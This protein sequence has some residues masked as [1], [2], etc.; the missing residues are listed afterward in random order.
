MIVMTSD[1]TARRLRVTCLSWLLCMGIGVS[2]TAYAVD[3]NEV[4]VAAS[5]FVQ[6]GVV[7][8]PVL[9]GSRMT[10]SQSSQRAILNWQSFNIGK[11]AG[12]TFVQPSSQAV[13][14]NKIYQADPSRI[15]GSLQANGHVYLINPN[16]IVFGENATVNVGS[17]VASTMGIKDR[18]VNDVGLLNAIKEGEAA[19]QA[20]Q[21]Y[22]DEDEAQA[23]FLQTYMELVNAELP[24]GMG[25][26]KIEP[27]AQLTADPNGFVL[28][29]AP[30]IE[31]K[32]KIETPNGQTILAAGNDKVYLAE[33]ADFRDAGL[34]GMLVEVDS[35][36]VLASE[37]ADFKA[38]HGLDIGEATNAAAGSI[39]A[40]RGNI[41]LMGMAVNQAGRVQA[42][43]AVD[44]G[45]SIRLVA[46]DTRVRRNESTGDINYQAEAYGSVTLGEDSVSEVIPDLGDTATGTDSNQQMPSRVEVV[47]R[48]VR[49]K[50]GSRLTARSGDIDVLAI[51]ATPA[52]L[53]APGVYD[54]ERF[55]NDPTLPGRAGVTGDGVSEL[56]V[57]ENV[58]FDV[59]GI[60]PDDWAAWVARHPE[61]AD[62]AN[63]LRVSV[64][65]NV[66]D[67]KVLGYELRD[68]PLQTDLEN[69]PQALLN[70]A[71]LH[72]DVRD[73]PDIADVSAAVA[74]FGRTVAERSTTGGTVALKSTGSLSIDSSVEIDVSGG[75]VEYL[76]G[77]VNTT[78]LISSDGLL[79]DIADAPKDIVYTQLL[80]PDDYGNRA[81]NY[82]A[83]YIEGKDA[84]TVELF[85]FDAPDSAFGGSVRG[86]VVQ[87]RHQRKP[88]S[89]V[90][91]LLRAYN[92]MPAGGALTLA[93]TG[94]LYLAGGPSRGSVRFYA[95][96]AMTGSP[97]RIEGFG[98]L[99]VI[100]MRD[101]VL[102]EGERLDLPAGGDY[103]FSAGNI[104]LYGSIVA[105]AS[106][107]SFTAAGTGLVTSS[108]I[109]VGENAVLDASGVWINDVGNTDIV[110]DA[111]YT[112]AGA[113]SL[114]V[115][116]LAP[117]N[118]LGTLRVNAGGRV[119]ASGD[120]HAGDGGDIVLRV[121]YDVAPGTP[122]LFIG[123]NLQAYTF[124]GAADS[125][126]TLQAPGFVL[127]GNGLRFDSLDD[128]NRLL[129][130]SGV[131]T[132]NGFSA[133]TLI[134]THQGM[135][136]VDG[137]KIVV[138]RDV[139]SLSNPE[140]V[141]HGADPFELARIGAPIDPA[142]SA[143]QL[144]LHQRTSA[145]ASVSSPLRIGVDALLQVSEHP[146]SRISLQSDTSLLL[147]SGS[148]LRA[149]SGE[150][151]L[152]IVAQ[153]N[154][155]H[156][157]GQA[158]WIG[159]GA[160]IDV[161]AAAD[162]YRIGDQVAGEI[163]DAGSI[164][165]RAERGY[166]IAAPGSRFDLSGGSALIDL[167]GG[168]AVDPRIRPGRLEHAAGG[169]LSLRTQQGMFFF[170]D[171]LAGVPDGNPLSGGKVSVRYSPDRLESVTRLG[172]ALFPLI[173]PQLVLSRLDAAAGDAGAKNW[174]QLSF[175]SPFDAVPA[176]Y[177]GQAWVDPE[178]LAASGVDSLEFIVRPYEGNASIRDESGTFVVPQDLGVSLEFHGD[179][180][181][182]VPDS[183]VLDAAVIASDG[184]TVNLEAAY[185]ALG[186]NNRE[187]FLGS[188][189]APYDAAAGSGSLRANAILIDLMG[190][191]A[192]QG[193]GG[194]GVGESA[195]VHLRAAED[196]RLRGVRRPRQVDAVGTLAAA[197]SL[198]LDAGR[199]T[200]VTSLTE[201]D[202]ALKT[203]RLAFSGGR[204]LPTD[205]IFSA[206]GTLSA[207]A[208]EIHQ[209]GVLM[210]PFGTIKLDA[211]NDLVL[212]ADS[213]TSVSGDGITMPFGVIGEEGVWLRAFGSDDGIGDPRILRALDAPPDK[214]IELL[215]NAVDIQ[216]DA[217]L[218]INGGGDLLAVTFV[219]GPGGSNDVLASTNA[220]GAFA[221]IPQSA[222]SYGTWDTAL[223]QDFPYTP[224][225]VIEIPEGTGG[226]LAPGVYA[227]YPPQYA[228][229]EGAVLVTPVGRGQLRP[230]QSIAGAD[231][232]TNVAGRLG[233]AG[234]GDF[235]PNW[236]SF[237]VETFEQVSKR[238]EYAVN[239]MD[240]LF[241]SLAAETATPV[242]EL[243]K[244]AGRL[245]LDAGS[246]LNLDGGLVTFNGLGRA[247]SVD[248]T[249][250]RIAILDVAEERAGYVVLTADGLQ[251]LGAESVL[252]GGTRNIDA[253]LSLIDVTASE[254]IVEDN[255]GDGMLLQL[256]ELLLVAKD[257]AANAFE[258][259]IGDGV[260]IATVAGALTGTARQQIVL[261]DD[262]AS[263]DVSIVGLSERGLYGFGGFE[264][265]GGAQSGLKI[266]NGA[267]LA[268]N[269][270]MALLAG[271]SLVRDGSVEVVEGATLFLAA[272][273]LSFN[274]L[275]DVAGSAL[276]LRADVI[277]V[278]NDAELAF[279]SLSIDAAGLVGKAGGGS[280][281]V[282]IAEELRFENS[283]DRVLENESGSMDA[284]RFNVERAAGDPADGVA[285]H[286]SLGSG[287]FSLRN[288]AD[289]S[290]RSGTLAADGT[291]SGDSVNASLVGDANLDIAADD[292]GVTG[293][294][295]LRL[296]AAQGLRLSRYGLDSENT[297]SSASIGLQGSIALAGA[298][299]ELNTALRA[300]SG[301]VNVRARSGDVV[302]GTIGD[303]SAASQAS[304]DVSGQPVLFDNIV[305]GT[306]GGFVSLISDIGNVRL[307]SGSRLR[308]DGHGAD[309]H[310]GG[311]TVSAAAGVVE[312][313][314]GATL[315]AFAADLD[316]AQGDLVV[317]AGRL[318]GGLSTLNALVE[319]NGFSESRYIR[320]GSGDLVLDAA[321]SINV[322]RLD[323]IADTGSI[324]IGGTLDTR[325]G[326]RNGKIALRAFDS[327]KL[328]GGAKVYAQASGASQLTSS[329]LLLE[330]TNAAGD[331]RLD[332]DV[333]MGVAGTVRLIAPRGSAADPLAAISSIDGSL[334]GVDRVELV[335]MRTYTVAAG[336][337]IS[338]VLGSIDADNDAF[339]ADV[340]PLANL[341]FGANPS[342]LHL[343]P[344]VTIKSSGDLIVDTHVDTFNWRSGS[345]D[346]VGLLR[347]IAGGDLSL[348][349]NTSVSAGFDRSA[350]GIDRLTQGRS[351]DLQLVAGADSGSADPLAVRRV[352]D[353]EAI[354]AGRIDLQS[355][356]LV[357][358]GTGDLDIVS[359]GDVLLEGEVYTAGRDA[360]GGSFTLA[361]GGTLDSSSY[362]S[363][364]LAHRAGSM[365]FARDGGDLN[366]VVGGNLKASSTADQYVNDWRL[367]TG[368]L[369][370]TVAETL[371]DLGG[372][373]LVIRNDTPPT[374]TGIAFQH[375][376]SHIGSLG[377][378]EQRI[379]IAGNVD[380]V[381]FNSAASARPIGLATLPEPNIM[382]TEINQFEMVGGGNT[383]VLIGGHY[384]GGSF[385]QALGNANLRVL[386]SIGGIG[387]NG[388]DSGA[389][390]LA[391]GD[392]SLRLE[393][394]GD[395]V[396]DSVYNPTLVAQSGNQPRAS[397]KTRFVSLGESSKIDLRATGGHVQLNNAALDMGSAFRQLSGETEDVSLA[398]YPSKLHITSF[399]GDIRL[400][401]ETYLMPARANASLRLLA[402]SDLQGDT[403][404]T[405]N[406]GQLIQPDVDPGLLPTWDRITGESLRLVDEA[407]AFNGG[408]LAHAADPVFGL[409]AEPN[410]LSAGGDIRYLTAALSKH[411]R[412]TAGD[413]IDSF[414]FEIQHSLVDGDNLTLIQAG[415]DITFPIGRDRGEGLFAPS[416]TPVQGVRVAGPGTLTMI[417]GGDIDLGASQGALTTGNIRNTALPD[418]GS[419]INLL[420]GMGSEPAYRQF[421]ETYLGDDARQ[422]QRYEIAFEFDGT[423]LSGTDIEAFENLFGGQSGYWLVGLSRYDSGISAVIEQKGTLSGGT[424]AFVE[425]VR[426]F[427]D[428]IAA[429]DGVA[430][431]TLIIPETPSTYRS[432]AREYVAGKMRSA[433]I[434]ED[435]AV[436]WLLDAND[437][438]EHLSFYLEI[439]NRELVA[440][441]QRAA[442]EESTVFFDRSKLAI[443]ALFPTA[444]TA[445]MQS[446]QGVAAA[447]A[448]N[449]QAEGAPVIAGDV[450]SAFRESRFVALNS[451]SI[452]S[453]NLAGSAPLDP[454][455]RIETDP[456]T[457]RITTGSI[458][459]G[460]AESL[461]RGD[462]VSLA[463]LIS[464]EDGGI[465]RVVAP[466]GGLVAGTIEQLKLS[467]GEDFNKTG[468]VV[469]KNG[470]LFVMTGQDVV[471]NSSK[472]IN[473]SSGGDLAIWS[474]FGNID[475]GRGLRGAL[476]EA[477]PFALDDLTGVI[478]PNDSPDIIGSGIQNSPSG[479]GGIGNT[480]LLT[481]LGVINAGTAGIQAESV[482]LFAA[483]VQNTE[484]LDFGNVTS[485]VSLG[486]GD[487]A[488][489]AT[490][491]G[492]TTN[493]T[494]LAG[495]PTEN[496]PPP[497]AG[498]G[499][500]QLASLS[501]EVVGFG[502][503][504]NDLP[505][506]SAGVIDCE[507]ERYRQRKE[508]RERL[509]STS[510]N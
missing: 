260:E 490:D 210:A 46:R 31:N 408:D 221:I 159:D 354:G 393:S 484:G 362:D 4:P 305:K 402:G 411:S 313:S 18:L 471:V 240:P 9:D 419:D 89:D 247:P 385:Y 504:V 30:G 336:G 270:G 107:L 193:F 150:I 195:P 244:D 77:Y 275:A 59:S 137:S 90:G 352:D 20:Y 52:G 6:S 396:V 455:T 320:V 41:T 374:A 510:V 263:A 417:A 441:G 111:L 232:V 456:Q 166:V 220:Q 277:E 40:D 251:G 474:S 157:D 8:A 358:T 489:V 170:G 217:Q 63:P 381:S 498:G 245:L 185:L 334:S 196:I 13:A 331:I 447:L 50:K 162:L 242:P 67:L 243:L 481:E 307:G 237:T 271:R 480:Y 231:G 164:N 449:A 228:V 22:E 82:E 501:V 173:K 122:E 189:A 407:F 288:F 26:V 476:V 363:S 364:Y 444:P 86:G 133:Y 300:P 206:G 104:E 392:A 248:I 140:R 99:D 202:I 426:A 293:L 465:A 327:V 249:G 469:P 422:P 154:D 310:A 267:T 491:I 343:M 332:A 467:S 259:A 39:V 238:A 346:A 405:G 19:F 33:P 11:N 475:A 286:V 136:V 123:G 197:G 507:N 211:A 176:A 317:N 109:E 79:F 344:G 199:A 261:D 203:G 93:R 482:T 434:S 226:P 500:E 303:P 463:S 239:R 292:I 183:L 201:F 380:N 415:G 190:R 340:G 84:G 171:V 439:L 194:A 302:L 281:V 468:V 289:V 23:E 179:L 155:R 236:S 493:P 391:L 57:E 92:E 152:R 360:G 145:F 230:G 235:A 398:L 119:D 200:Y 294:G 477:A 118:M 116:S 87:G 298:F 345:G 429:R 472:I 431:V 278:D 37:R 287:T 34:V 62:M 208:P 7:A 495:D 316:N 356:T 175:A 353:T 264:T 384:T 156:R 168:N 198:T 505:A 108:S 24:E 341:G 258:I 399:T 66:L 368:T 129:I 110:R 73:L 404:A 318:A 106:T 347:L 178:A 223:S 348:S 68:S 428:A 509:P 483:V 282:N 280:L 91:G 16:G 437:Q 315:S 262:A 451:A 61:Y 127:G 180:D 351:W 101:L 423:T 325:V 454:S 257:T 478:I 43:T 406:W 400:R 163:Y 488:P 191:L 250:D 349:S 297:L 432:L 246:F 49:I 390:T 326:D 457:G 177:Q 369:E 70:G 174:D 143:T 268:A 435:D 296:D 283:R 65:R 42:T 276:V 214:R 126:L 339:F 328:A 333:D 54:A 204:S 21:T 241:E 120:F 416:E 290:I 233:N 71:T 430:P 38:S 337:T 322:A 397:Y 105:P 466:G 51:S 234:T 25:V 386:G 58:R 5:N 88:S 377:G 48:Q 379:R 172:S 148:T 306:S 464:P 72:F 167:P 494:E 215:G 12:V 218:D 279:E 213:L 453:V 29:I 272:E 470:D 506:P 401:N 274:E 10:I 497:D 350:P 216:S 304:I 335:G 382:K 147:D 132:R 371:L 479:E 323:L 75:Y 330:V 160:L 414:W 14:V 153:D 499:E 187:F 186:S 443:K 366:L 3:D 207:S 342:R 256:S 142:N 64:E 448:L 492:V 253:N 329:T 94:E 151:S 446:E 394:G 496:L 309:G 28:V 473:R 438:R 265:G 436:R 375:F 373:I 45:G 112:D 81:D 78:R 452:D 32:G 291:T 124:G 181:V 60:T 98:V 103:R 2:G 321:E 421:V 130:G 53:P 56:V 141:A 97:L 319:G 367:R 222:G 252:I 370:G 138:S 188:D 182:A 461:Y 224:G 80:S 161:S 229:V 445:P 114:S 508:C 361:E 36:T 301:R 338:G 425:P 269:G 47:G 355:N 314:A 255:D 440:G 433:D 460:L 503:D 409:D 365:V 273:K 395:L 450:L 121:D 100:A 35:K 324:D 128:D 284:L 27:N 462:I 295:E 169:S 410:V 85:A 299:V 442:I 15:M 376:D 388:D 266:A 459:A 192:L 149:R 227:L 165:V 383:D 209:Q 412:V 502:G 420:A 389:L 113:I 95:D 1:A 131:F 485:N 74:A 205:G 311:L 96:A 486:T 378:G 184:G 487:T 387:A 308:M 418:G 219:P 115:E 254:V 372:F 17:L 144:T 158:I 212:T 76:G 44:V 413:D 55:K 135:D 357:R 359:S 312:L 69:N 424:P 225:T 117:L 102:P 146:S 139:M 125:S 427:V 403:S 285:G 83:G 458:E 134:A